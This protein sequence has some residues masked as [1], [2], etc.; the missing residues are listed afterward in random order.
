ME[1]WIVESIHYAEFEWRTLALA[2]EAKTCVLLVSLVG[3]RIVPSGKR[4]KTDVF[5]DVFC[6]P[7]LTRASESV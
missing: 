7:A 6:L 3:L 4:A 1:N 2:A 5:F